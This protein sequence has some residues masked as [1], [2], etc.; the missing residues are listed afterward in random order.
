MF[1]EYYETRIMLNKY[2]ELDKSK[3]HFKQFSPLLLKIFR[4]LQNRL[5]AVHEC[6]FLMLIISCI[7][8]CQDANFVNVFNTISVSLCLLFCPYFLFFTIKI[9]LKINSENYSLEYKL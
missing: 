6:Y 3:Y 9:Y 1:L 8:Q 7:L 5:V 4:F 2:S